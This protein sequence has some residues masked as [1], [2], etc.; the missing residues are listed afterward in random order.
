MFQK[1]K[2]KKTA[3]ATAQGWRGQ[4]GFGK[5]HSNSICPATDRK[6]ATLDLWAGAQLGRPWGH[7]LNPSLKITG[8]FY[9]HAEISPKIQVDG[10]YEVGPAKPASLRNIMQTI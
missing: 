7:G 4:S 5:T 6:E 1:K 3:Q 10:N 9:S 8:S 2:K